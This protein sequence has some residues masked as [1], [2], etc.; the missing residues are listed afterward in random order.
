M[1]TI[2]YRTRYQ[3]EKKSD[4]DQKLVD[5][6]RVARVMA[7][8]RRFSFRA[9]VV[10]GD[11]KGQVGFGLGKGADTALSIEKA[12]RAAKK[13]LIRVPLTP[14]GSIPHEITAKFGSARVLLRPSQ[15]GLRA[16]GAVRVVL[17]LAGVKNASAKILSRTKNKITNAR[18][19]LAALQG[20]KSNPHAV[21]RT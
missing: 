18:A 4:F 12:T 15:G 14:E 8:G 3:R 2:G 13:N 7:G 16:G 5:L 19:A 17:D 20:L 21:S 11:R 9:A 1:A 6:R 10:L